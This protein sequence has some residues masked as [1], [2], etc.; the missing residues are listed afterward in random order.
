MSRGS[1]QGWLVA[2]GLVL[3]AAAG[4]DPAR[5]AD[6]AAWYNALAPHGDGVALRLAAGGQAA[7]DLLVPPGPTTRERKAAEELSRWLQAMTG[8]QFAV[9]EEG[10][11]TLLRSCVTAG[12]RASCAADSAARARLGKAGASSETCAPGGTDAC[13]AA[14]GAGRSVISLGHTR[15]LTA[16]G[17]GGLAEG[18]GPE[19][20]AIAARGGDLFLV[21]GKRRGPITAVFALLEE[22][23]GC[24]W[25]APRAQRIPRRDELTAMVV[26]RSYSPAFAVRD[27]FSYVSNDADWALRNRANPYGAGVPE[28]W[29]GNIDYAPGW[30]VHT[31]ERILAGTRQNV[32]AWPECFMLDE[33][34][35]RSPRQLCPTHPHVVDLAISS[36][37]RLL[38]EHPEA[39]LV[40]VSQNDIRGYC[41]CPRCMA[42]IEAQGTPAAP[43]LY[44]VNR[45]AEAV[46]QAH[47]DVT[48]TFLG[49]QDTV[50]APRTLRPAANVAVRLATDI[51]WS[52]PFTPAS[53]SQPFMEALTGWERVADRIH[54]WDYQV[55]F[56]DYFQ[57]WPSLPARAENLRLFAGHHVT[58][59]MVEGA[60]QGPGAESQLL[61][62]WVLA[63]LLW[64]PT[65]D[66]WPL[67]QDFVRGYYGPAAAPIEAYYRMLYD[68]GC[69]GKGVAD[70]LGAEAF[71]RRASSLFDRAEMIAFTA[72][73]ADADELLDRV[74][75]ARLP[76]LDVALP[77]ARGRWITSEDSLDLERYRATLARFAT[78]ARLAGTEQYSEG[79]KLS[80]W[81]EQRRAIVAVPAP[82]GERTADLK[83]RPVTVYR[84]PASWV[85]QQDADGLG[86]SEGWF[87]A[88][89]EDQDWGHYRTDLAAGWEE[90]G[91]P[92]QDGLFW[93][94]QNVV[95]PASCAKPY[96]YLYFRACD[97]EAWVWVDGLPLGERT[98]AS[99]GIE[100]QRLWLTPFALEAGRRLRPGTAHAV[101]VRVSDTGGMGGLYLPVFVIASD[102]PL[103]CEQM[104]GLVAMRNP[105]E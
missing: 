10:V 75:L 33:D 28:E 2:A 65:R 105:Y 60:Y 42:L 56:G 5:A 37:R 48:I 45:V 62:A 4:G 87:A 29:G 71:V 9:V 104:T 81:V 38:E 11:P 77:L 36:V 67:V 57:P 32:A 95:L 68:C 96:V 53:K 79:V 73:G 82:A 22:D 30:F 78:A 88:N 49:Y 54:I 93:F 92:D 31:Y 58:G 46:A 91:Y 13:A 103:T 101:A 26:P 17:L 14:G 85:V 47:P 50:P 39:E 55:N 51:T 66:L 44:L 21:G 43:L 76:V 70:C 12:S 80:G 89:Y 16:A 35:T 63:K 84:L 3:G 69:A 64:D 100:P 52:Q 40:D 97:E 7:C 99:T 27:P 90:Q 98:V 72:G 23:L 59:V 19:G 18:L 41:H 15:R 34:G 86:E 83:G 24:R 1:L 20:Y 25:Y 61:R 94:R 8:A 6:D 74:E 102:V